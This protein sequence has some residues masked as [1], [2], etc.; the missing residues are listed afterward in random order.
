M[1]QT[2]ISFKKWATDPVNFFV[3]EIFSRRLKKKNSTNKSHVYLVHDSW[4]SDILDLKFYGPE[5]ISGY[6]Y[7]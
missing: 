1:T 3:D 5:N 7:I 4:S 2:S 6:R